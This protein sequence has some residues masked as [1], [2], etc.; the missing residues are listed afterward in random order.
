[1]RH[2]TDIL[3]FFFARNSFDQQFVQSFTWIVKIILKVD[4]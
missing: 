1:M 3:N 2:N 4:L